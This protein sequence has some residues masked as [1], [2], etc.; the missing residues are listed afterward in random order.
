MPHWTSHWLVR[1]LVVIIIVILLAI[2]L[3]A[4]GGFDWHF[5]AGHFHWDIGVTKGA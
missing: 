5:T 3:S 4:L 2:I 1:V